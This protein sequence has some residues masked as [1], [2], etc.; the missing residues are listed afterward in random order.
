MAADVLVFGNV[1]HPPFIDRYIPNAQT[2]AWDDLGQRNPL[3]VCQHTMVGTLWGTDTHFRS[4][5]AGLTDYGIGGATDGKYDGVILRW[6]DPRSRR[7]G[8]ASGGSD[9]LEGPG[10]PFVR[11]LGVAAINRDLVSIERSDGGDITTPMSPKQFES[12]CQLTAFWMDQAEVPWY[13][14]PTNPAVQLITHLMHFQFATKGCP[15]A[16][17]IDNWTRIQ[18]RVRAILR[19]AQVL[20]APGPDPV[21]VPPLPEWPNGW[22]TAA[23]EAQFG[24]LLE[25]TISKRNE[26]AATH[27]RGFNKNGTISNMWV[28][29]CAAERIK[30]IS[31]MPKPSHVTITASKDGVSS[32][33]LI[34]PRSGYT[35]WVAVKMDGNATWK[36]ER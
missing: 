3:G 14:Y 23:L 22:T 1:P 18:D 8:W 21:P 35:D 33:T 36:W 31:R 16:Q 11:H 27:L 9:G 17:I 29:R 5:G 30:A 15:W 7:S 24:Q 4:G 28:A 13:S 19:S 2:F 34:V 6:N 32:S 12:I 25:I 10:V 20:I 26:I